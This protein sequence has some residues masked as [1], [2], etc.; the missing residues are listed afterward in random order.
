MARDAAFFF[1]ARAHVSSRFGRV[2]RRVTWQQTFFSASE[3]LSL[4]FAK[5]S[6]T[7]LIEARVVVKQNTAFMLQRSTHLLL[8]RW[9]SLMQ[10]PLTQRHSM[11]AH[12]SNRS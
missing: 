7:N 5:L 12:I 2:W 11:I 4:E 1:S 8:V 9:V 6:R 3:P 10:K